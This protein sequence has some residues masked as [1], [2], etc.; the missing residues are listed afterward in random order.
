MELSL[1]V[2]TVSEHTVLEVGGEIDVYTAEKLRGRLR[3]IIN[4]GEKHVVVDLSKV[5]FLDSTGLGVLVGANRR[6]QARDGSS[7]DLVCPHER[8]LK[9]FRIT[10]LDSVFQIH[11]SVED[12]TKGGAAARAARAA[13]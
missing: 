6:L 5:E 9:V 10:G 8:L 1:A 7:L 12:A 4:S 11:A 2:R 13:S 3:D